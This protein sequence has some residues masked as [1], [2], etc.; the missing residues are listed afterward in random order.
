MQGNQSLP[1]FNEY[2]EVYD[3]NGVKLGQIDHVEGDSI[4]IQKGLISLTYHSIPT[5]FVAE[6]D[7]NNVYLSVSGD[8][9][10][11]GE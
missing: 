3:V 6:A 5:R 1:T 4:V 2:A 11:A 7:A 8:V 10:Y 9:A